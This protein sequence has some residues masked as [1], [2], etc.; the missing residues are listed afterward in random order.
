[1]ETPSEQIL[2]MNLTRIMRAKEAR[3]VRSFAKSLRYPIPDRTINRILKGSENEGGSSPT[4]TMLDRLAQNFPGPTY[5][6][7]IPDAPIT[8][9]EIVE[10]DILI[11]QYL[12]ASDEA[13]AAILRYVELESRFGGDL[14]D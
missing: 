14:H 12:A 9:R 11:K 10:L 1:M 2:T 7:L 8:K 13:K 4:L 5:T 6:L 3:S